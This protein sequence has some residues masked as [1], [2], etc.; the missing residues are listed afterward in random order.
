[1]TQI[2]TTTT[3]PV[4]TQMT[5]LPV[6]WITHQPALHHLSEQLSQCA[7]LAFDT[8]FI[9]RNTYYPILALVQINT[10]EA[11]YLIDAPTLN[12]TPLWRAFSQ[13]KLL[14]CH[15]C[16]EDLGIFYQLSQLPPLS[17][18]FD[19]Q[20]GLSFLGKDLQVG[21]QT[22]LQMV[23]NVN[24]DKE[25]SQ[26]DW[27]QRP[28]TPK[29]TAYAVNDVRF[30]PSLYIQIKHQLEQNNIYDF[31]MQDCQSYAYELAQTTTDTELY[32]EMADFRYTPKQ[33]AQLQQ[34]MLWREQLAITTNQPRTFILKKTA[35]R[36]LVENPPHNIKALFAIK[37][38][39]PSIIKKYGQHILACLHQLPNVTDYPPPVARPYRNKDKTLQ[40]QVDSLV[41]TIAK[42]T[43]VS[44]AVLL[45]K[46]WRTQ[47]YTHVAYQPLMTQTQ[48]TPLQNPYLTGW[49]FDCLTQPL[50]ALLKQHQTELTQHIVPHSLQRSTNQL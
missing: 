40:K 23:L 37:D 16:G 20:I 21:Y 24:I 2:Q 22:A 28:L 29:Q 15:A 14:V 27:L 8:E 10:G 12:L 18:I 47:L 30:L 38:I 42:Q 7:L 36:N 9:K 3:P 34:L 33:L 11:I 45:R 48:H 41:K 25:E 17:N 43:G 6:H 19:T 50:L 31:A 49:R 32:L 1:M 35:L 46:K 26:S 39:K 13:A 44:T 4:T 5:N